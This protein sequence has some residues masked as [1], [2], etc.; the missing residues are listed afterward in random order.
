[1]SPRILV[2]LCSALLLLPAV[3]CNRS[4]S[5]DGRASA[6][7]D[8]RCE[9]DIKAASCPFCNPETIAAEGFCG[10]HGVEEALCAQCRPHLKAAFRAQGDWCAEHALPESQCVACNPELAEKIQEGVHGAP[11][12]TSAAAEGACPHGIDEASCPF[13]TPALIDSEGWCRGH[14]VAEALCVKCRPYL[15]TA[16]QAK[17]DWCAEHDT[18]ESQCALCG[19]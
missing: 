2:L 9:H 8:G 3:G 1:M 12:S 6:S 7:A 4:S 11:I 5:A 18:P 19:A 17:G 10:T 13:C 16:F 15:A 14:D